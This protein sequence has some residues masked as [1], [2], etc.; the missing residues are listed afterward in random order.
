[1]SEIINE[2]LHHFWI[3]TE[4]KG[5]KREEKESISK[6]TTKLTIFQIKKKV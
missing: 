4:K 2:F 5:E 1:M 3:L 6:I